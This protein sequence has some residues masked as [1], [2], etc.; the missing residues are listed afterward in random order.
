MFCFVLSFFLLSG[1]IAF[2][3]IRSQHCAGS[4]ECHL[5]LRQLR[6]QRSQAEVRLHEH[7]PLGADLK[8]ESSGFRGCGV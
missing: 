2:Y 3:G 4:E 7:G 5:S 6:G 8:P 1:Y